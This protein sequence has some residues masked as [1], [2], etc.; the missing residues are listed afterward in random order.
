MLQRGTLSVRPCVRLC[1]TTPTDRGNRL[2]IDKFEPF[3]ASFEESKH[4]IVYVITRDVSMVTMLTYVTAFHHPFI[5]GTA[6]TNR[7]FLINV[8]FPRWVPK[9]DISRY[10]TSLCNYC[11]GNKLELGVSSVL[12]YIASCTSCF[13]DS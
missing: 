5:Q 6:V 3:F 13:S 11:Y 8:C 1:A 9:I 2:G 12:T 10:L 7:S 4:T